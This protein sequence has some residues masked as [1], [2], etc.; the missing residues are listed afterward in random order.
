LS[1][2]VFLFSDCFSVLPFAISPDRP[3]RVDREDTRVGGTVFRL[4]LIVTVSVVLT[5][6][7]FKR[8]GDYS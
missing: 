1:R 2:A 4:E 6:D 7:D 3:V 5:A 8:A